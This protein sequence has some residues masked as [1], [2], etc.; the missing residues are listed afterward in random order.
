MLQLKD[1][2]AARGLSQRALA[3]R[4]GVGE[5]TVL[6]IERGKTSPMPHVARRLSAALGVEP[7]EVAEFRPDP[8]R[9]G[10]PSLAAR[11]TVRQIRV[12]GR[13]LLVPRT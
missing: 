3:D 2:R 8:G 6:R 13:V 4:A 7:G 10:V 1:A 12:G 9:G 11:I 5:S